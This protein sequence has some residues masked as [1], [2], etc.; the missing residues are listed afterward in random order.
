[1]GLGL[2]TDAGDYV[3]SE[4]FTEDYQ[5]IV[6][7]SEKAKH[8]AESRWDKERERKADA[9]ADALRT[10]EKPKPKRPLVAK[11]AITDIPETEEIKKLRE[12]VNELVNLGKDATV[13]KPNNVC[14][15]LSNAQ[16]QKLIDKHGIND[17][18][19]RK[20]YLWKFGTDKSVK[21]DYLSILNNMEKDWLRNEATDKQQTDNVKRH[22]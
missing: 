19:L 18:T 8:S 20:Y 3:F 1:I 21:D 9:D 5:G 12:S 14:C 11:S 17:K 10:H 16:F 22:F 7:K 4:R 15:T 2:L 6:A 13:K